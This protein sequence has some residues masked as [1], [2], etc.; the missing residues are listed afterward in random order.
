MNGLSLS[1]ASTIETAKDDQGTITAAVCVSS[2]HTILKALKRV[3]DGRLP[4]TRI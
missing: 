1:A 3:S 4:I 2:S